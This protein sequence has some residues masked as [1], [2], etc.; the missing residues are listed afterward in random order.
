M[1]TIPVKMSARTLLF[2]L[3]TL[4]PVLALAC[5]GIDARLGFDRF[6]PPQ[7]TSKQ[8]D[9]VARYI[10]YLQSADKIIGGDAIDADP[11]LVEAEALRWIAGKKANELVELLPVANDDISLEGPKSDI[12]VARNT[13]ARMLFRKAQQPQT[14]TPD[15][16]VWWLLTALRLLEVGKY[17]D[18]NSVYS[19][20][21]A[22]RRILPALESIGLAL[23]KPQQVELAGELAALQDSARP[24]DPIVALAEQQYKAWVEVHGAPVDVIERPGMMSLVADDHGLPIPER[25]RRLASRITDV[26]T[27]A[28]RYIA[29]TK[30]ALTSS[31]SLRAE[32]DALIRKLR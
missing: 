31:A 22:Q 18:L 14:G 2:R 13:M 7:M 9:D 30:V 27:T 16:H 6:D 1:P 5:V 4:L 26:T 23:P 10:P 29:T 28:P 17:S 3:L 20:N 24:L 15:E 11:R 32:T 19:S 8:F 12:F 21:I 25:D